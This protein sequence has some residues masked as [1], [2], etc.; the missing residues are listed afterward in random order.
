MVNYL[1]QVKVSEIGIQGQLK[2]NNAKVLVIG[3]GGLGTPL[4]TYLTLM[5]IGNIGIVDFDIIQESN[6]HRQF[7]YNA[8]EIGEKKVEIICKKLKLINNDITIKGID[9]KIDIFNS[10]S[11]IKDYDII[12]DCTDDASSR[13]IIDKSCNTL[14]KPLVYAAVRDWQGYITILNHFNKIQL[15]DI[16]SIDDLKFENENNCNNMGIVSS[17]CGTIASFQATEVLKLILHFVSNL[18]GNILC[19]NGLFN[20]VRFFKINRGS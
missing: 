20:S 3:A 15:N 18:D 19:Y 2:I 10:N 8:I 11:I 5:G 17:V 13:I 12:C 16:F 14:M 9:T 1:Q 6:L 7:H 4:C